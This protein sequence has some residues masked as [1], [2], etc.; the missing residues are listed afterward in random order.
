[1]APKWVM[2]LFPAVQSLE[3]ENATWRESLQQLTNEKLLLQDRLDAAI[4]ERARVW[5]MAA[6]GFARRAH[7]LP[8]AHQSELAASYR[9]R[10]LSRCTALGASQAAR[11]KLG[12]YRQGRPDSPER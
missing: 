3:A 5:R 7:R 1:M 2:R 6:G 11:A 10:S 4:D 12:T 9:Y 8:D